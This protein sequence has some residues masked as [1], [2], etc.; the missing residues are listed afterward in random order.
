MAHSLTSSRSLLMLVTEPSSISCKHSC[1]AL[2]SD[3]RAGTLSSVFLLCQLVQPVRGRGSALEG[4]GQK[5]DEPVPP[6]LL[7]VMVRL[8]QPWH[9]IQLG[10]LHPHRS[11]WFTGNSSVLPEA[12]PRV[13]AAESLL[14]APDIPAPA[15]QRPLFWVSGCWSPQPCSLGPQS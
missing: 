6:C 13:P 15:G 10:T 11:S 3:A 1:H 2:P 5:E 9:F 4:G 12:A 8:P 7:A 14:Q